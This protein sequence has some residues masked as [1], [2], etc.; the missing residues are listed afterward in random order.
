MF[1]THKTHL[2]NLVR[3]DTPEGVDSVVVPVSMRHII[4]NMW[5]DVKSKEKERSRRKIRH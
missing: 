5:P 2:F 4:V 3:R 1:K